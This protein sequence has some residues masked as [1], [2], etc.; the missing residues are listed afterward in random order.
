MNGIRQT[1]ASDTRTHTQYFVHL[2]DLE[3]VLQI[4]RSRRALELDG[5]YCQM[6]NDVIGICALCAVR[7]MPPA[8]FD[9]ST[10]FFCFFIAIAITIIII[11]T[12]ASFYHAVNNGAHATFCGHKFVA[13]LHAVSSLARRIEHTHTFDCLFK[14]CFGVLIYMDIIAAISFVFGIH[15]NEHRLRQMTLCS[16]FSSHT[17]HTLTRV[18]NIHSI[19]HISFLPLFDFCIHSVFFVIIIQRAAPAFCVRV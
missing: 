11:C 8:P 3:N 16:V 18:F 10:F 1:M 2:F 13:S 19:H 7:W 12:P 17:S 9:S 14:I 15:R 4:C 6:K 5:I